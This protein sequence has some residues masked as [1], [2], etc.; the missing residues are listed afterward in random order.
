MVKCSDAPV[1]GVDPIE[2]VIAYID[3]YTSTYLPTE[4]QDVD[5]HNLV[6][7]QM[8]RHTNTCSSNE[9]RVGSIIQ[10]KYLVERSL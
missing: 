1:L 3:K 7:L 8:H 4:E 6:K 9:K 5:L 2:D 10:D